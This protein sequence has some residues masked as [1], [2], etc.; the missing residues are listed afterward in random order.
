MYVYPK[1]AVRSIE[2]GKA[3][4]AVRK[5]EVDSASEE[6]YLIY[7]EAG[8]AHVRISNNPS[9][10]FSSYGLEYSIG[11]AD[12]VAIEFDAEWKES[13]FSKKWRPVTLGEPWLFKVNG[14]QL[15]AQKGETLNPL[16]LDTGDITSISSVRGWQNRFRP[17]EDHGV[18]VGYI[19]GGEPYIIQYCYTE[20][21]TRQWQA[22][23]HITGYSGASAI[24]LYRTNDYRLGM[25]ITI[26]T[27]IYNVLS[28]RNWGGMGAPKETVGLNDMNF[29]ATLRNL[30]YDENRQHE[31]TVAMASL[32]IQA[33]MSPVDGINTFTSAYNEGE[34]I[35]YVTHEYGFKDLHPDSFQVT[36]SMANTFGIQTVEQ[37]N[38]NTLKLTC[39]PFNNAR[40]DMAVTYLP[41]NTTT[42]PTGTYYPEFSITFTPEGLVPD[43]DPPTVSSII[44]T[45]V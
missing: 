1:T 18:V 8:E 30:A 4:I 31:E 27:E 16:V 21:G 26:G 44:N 41:N 20:Q 34:T 3:D 43:V 40:D 5:T 29:S 38:V 39:A 25:L 7:I 22:A 28:E 12:L 2:A 42:T 13:S 33:L 6:L 10:A 36:D 23:K 32:G 9:T 37:H 24:R 17:H 11:A 45:E 15:T 19:K 14:A 35:L